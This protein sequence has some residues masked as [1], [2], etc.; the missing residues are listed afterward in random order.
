[1]TALVLDK[2]E[3]GCFKDQ[4]GAFFNPEF[5]REGTAIHDAKNP[6][7]IIIGASSD[8]AA[9]LVQRMYTECLGDKADNI[10]TMS[11]ESGELCKYVSNSFLATKISFANE[12]ANITERIPGA[13]FDDVV[14]GMSADSR[15]CEKFFGSG[16]GYGGSC[17][18]KDVSGLIMLAKDD[19]G[20]DTHILEAAQRVNAER[21]ERILEILSEHVPDVKGMKIA[22]LGIAFKPGTDDTRESPALKVIQQLSVLGANV[23][24]HDPLL[25][26]MEIPE[27]VHSQASFTENVEE[28]LENSEACI[29]MTE[30]IE[31]IDLGPEAIT[32]TMSN[33]LLIDGRRAF[34][35]YDIPSGITYR[36]I[37]RPN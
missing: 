14:K 18:P 30:W 4:L 10:I 28:C 16:V 8:R 20:V 25:D 29:L 35:R 9:G 6:D 22:V 27:E 7:R 17:F 34:I 31:Y 13:D 11:L 2:I 23:W 33:K 32:A 37:G 1:T 21:T 5:L 19:L 24:A 15:I 3:N 12:I 36:A 26:E